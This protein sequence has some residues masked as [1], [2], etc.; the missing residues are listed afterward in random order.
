ME[1]ENQVEEGQE[2]SERNKLKGTVRQN[3]RL[4]RT[5]FAHLISV[6]DGVENKSRAI[7]MR[8]SAGEEYS[9]NNIS[10]GKR[11][12]SS[13][14]KRNYNTLLSRLFARADEGESG[15]GSEQFPSS[16]KR[17]R[18]RRISSAEKEEKF[19]TLLSR[20]LEQDRPSARVRVRGHE[21]DNGGAAEQFPS[22][23]IREEHTSDNNN[24]SVCLEAFQLGEDAREMPCSHI[25]HGNCIF[26]WL[27]INVTCP[28]CRYRIKSPSSSSS[29]FNNSRSFSP[30]RSPSRRFSAYRLSHS[31]HFSHSPSGSSPAKS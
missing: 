8:R 13:P 26:K 28:L 14:E 21:A 6:A 11:R 5:P 9:E 4:R 1:R 19:K 17:R 2:A 22:I 18:R 16:K 30:H 10:S 29:A 3:H 7:N 31:N 15:G 27:T 20:L 25:F 12:R 24:C 23:S